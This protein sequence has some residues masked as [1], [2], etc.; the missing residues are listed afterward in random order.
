MNKLPS[1]PSLV[2]QVGLIPGKGLC[3]RNEQQE[4][5]VISAHGISLQPY[6]FSDL[7]L[8]ALRF[9]DDQHKTHLIGVNS[10][11]QILIDDHTAPIELTSPNGSKFSLSVMDDGTLITKRL[12][13]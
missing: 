11:G 2:G 10:K 5:T 3:A 4:W 7:T 12:E 9:E 13:G 6:D 1:R 8:P